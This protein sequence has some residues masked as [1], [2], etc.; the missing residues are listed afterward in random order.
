MEQLKRAQNSL[1]VVGCYDDFEIY[2]TVSCNFTYVSNT[3]GFN[4]TN[5]YSLKAVRGGR[6]VDPIRPYIHADYDGTC[7]AI[8]GTSM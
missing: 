2:L 5:G 1:N 8:V 4:C 3:L 6:V 7:I